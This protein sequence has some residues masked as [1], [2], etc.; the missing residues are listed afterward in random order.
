MAVEINGEELLAGAIVLTACRD[1]LECKKKIRDRSYDEKLVEECE[2]SIKSTL[3]FFRS[4]W[5]GVLTTIDPEYLICILNKKFE[6]GD[7]SMGSITV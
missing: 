7:M 6:E 1:Y 4:K 3:R 2:R 5:F